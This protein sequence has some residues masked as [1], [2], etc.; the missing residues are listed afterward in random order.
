MK[1]VPGA[2]VKTVFGELGII[3]K[4]ATLDF[5][6]SD[7]GAGFYI[8]TLISKNPNYTLWF[9]RYNEVHLLDENG[10]IDLKP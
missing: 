1:K 4:I 2:L 8:W 6:R 3:V 9:R 7:L 10:L 5:S